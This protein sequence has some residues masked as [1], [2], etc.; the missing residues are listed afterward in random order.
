MDIF[1]NLLQFWQ[2]FKIDINQFYSYHML[3][4]NQLGRMLKT[5]SKN[6]QKP[7]IDTHFK[8]ACFIHQKHT[9]LSQFLWKPIFI[10]D[11]DQSS[12]LCDKFVDISLKLRGKF[13]FYLPP[14]LILHKTTFISGYFS[15]LL[16]QNNPQKVL[17]ERKYAL[18]SIFMPISIRFLLVL[19]E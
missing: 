3:V 12:Q 1:Q 18:F 7:W 8:I 13:W 15:Y 5:A 10:E 4:Y 16:L 2:N 14:V 6:I 17:L 19:M 9:I 11:G